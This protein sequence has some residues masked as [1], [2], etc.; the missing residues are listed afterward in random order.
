MSKPF[1]PPS[2]MCTVCGMRSMTKSRSASMC[3]AP[4]LAKSNVMCLMK[5]VPSKN[6]FQAT[7]TNWRLKPLNFHCAHFWKFA[8]CC[9]NAKKLPSSMCAKKTPLHNRT[10]CLRPTCLWV[11]LRSMP[12]AGFRSATHPSWCMAK[13]KMATIWPCLPHVFSNAWATPKCICLL[14]I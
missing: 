9:C 2:A 14:A 12:T 6:S 13:T 5:T 1:R 8:K 7:A 11:A 10:L 4:I 3:M